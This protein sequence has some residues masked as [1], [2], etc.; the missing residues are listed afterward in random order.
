MAKTPWH[1][2]AVAI[3]ALLWNSM[4]ALD[5]VMTHSGNEAYLS[6]FS[7]AE[8]ALFTGFPTWVVATWALSIWSAVAAAILMFFRSRFIVPLYW[9]SAVFFVITCVHNYLLSETPM[10][11]VV[12]TFALIFSCI[13]AAIIAF[14]LWYTTRA[15]AKGLL[16]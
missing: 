5:Y 4:G 10:H 11:Q 7:D 6:N 15:K 14:L 8:R 2:W 9:I 16:R 3:F 1:F 13:I 12:G